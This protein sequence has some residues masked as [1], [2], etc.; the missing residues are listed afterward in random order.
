MNKADRDY[1]YRMIDNY[2]PYVTAVLCLSMAHR[3]LYEAE[4]KK[5]SVRDKYV[6]KAREYF[7]FVNEHLYACVSSAGALQLYQDVKHLLGVDLLNKRCV[8]ND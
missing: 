7:T 3:Y 1:L 4:S 2:G 8:H 6:K 5:P